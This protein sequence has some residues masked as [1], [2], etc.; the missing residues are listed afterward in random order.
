EDLHPVES[1][2]GGGVQ[3][4]LERARQAHRG[5][6]GS[7]RDLS[8]WTTSISSKLSPFVSLAVIA[9]NPTAMQTPAV[10]AD[11]D[12]Q[13]SPPTPPTALQAPA[14]KPEP[15]TQFSAPAPA[16]AE[17]STGARP[18]ETAKPIWVPRANPV[19]RDV[20]GNISA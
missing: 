8:S 5:D 18:P 12:T 20:V 7:H 17:A 1:R 6:R 19:T 9:P 10:N 3:L 16:T 14:V 13:F 11:T 4:L 15:D 2:P